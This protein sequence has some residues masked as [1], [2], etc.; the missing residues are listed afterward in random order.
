MGRRPVYMFSGPKNTAQYFS[1]CPRHLALRFRRFRHDVFRDL[2]GSIELSWCLLS[3]GSLQYPL[4]VRLIAY[5]VSSIYYLL[6]IYLISFNHAWVSC[7]L[8]CQQTNEPP[9]F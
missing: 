9:S 8:G 6:A 5:P 7:A 2:V 1:W 3:F 4:A